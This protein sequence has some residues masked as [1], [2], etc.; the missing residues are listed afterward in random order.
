MIP[1]DLVV[2]SINASTREQHFANQEYVK[3]LPLAK[4]GY[5]VFTREMF[6]AGT[7]TKAACY[8]A[9]FVRNHQ[10]KGTFK[11]GWLQD[12]GTLMANLGIMAPTAPPLVNVSTKKCT[13]AL[14]FIRDYRFIEINGA[15]WLLH[16]EDLLS[17]MQWQ[18][19]VVLMES[20]LH[21]IFE[22]SWGITPPQAQ[23]EPAQSESGQ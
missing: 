22:Y 15:E 16:F 17:K 20:K 19:S 21:G 14:L 12:F 11:A 5:T 2:G 23:K 10:D 13:Y 4:A 8:V 6:D 1:I 9:Q 3:T 7:A 18:S